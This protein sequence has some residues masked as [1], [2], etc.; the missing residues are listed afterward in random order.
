MA[1]ELIYKHQQKTYELMKD[2]LEKNGRAAYVFPTGCGKSFPALKYVD[3]NPD[4]KVSIFAPNLAIKNQYKKYIETYVENGKERLKSGNIE[5]KTYQ[6]IY[7]AKKEKKERA[8]K[9]RDKKTLNSIRRNMKSFSL[10]N[11]FDVDSEELLDEK[12]EVLTKLKNGITP[13]KIDNYYK[14]LK[15]YPKDE[16]QILDL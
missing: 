6:H 4:K 11:F 12:I 15:L 13:D 14:I 10:K 2:S 7:E 3:E 8:K 5:I 9:A 16:N 1:V